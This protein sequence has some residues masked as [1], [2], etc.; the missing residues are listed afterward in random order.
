MQQNVQ[1]S[2]PDEEN[3]TANCIESARSVADH[4]VDVSGIL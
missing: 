1:Q 3:A 2:K 4:V